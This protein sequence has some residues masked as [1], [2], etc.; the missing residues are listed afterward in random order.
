M[1]Y[2]AIYN[3]VWE[4]LNDNIQEPNCGHVIPDNAK[5][6]PECGQPVELVDT[7]AKIR[8]YLKKNQ[9]DFYGIDEDGKSTGSAKWYEYD[10]N[11]LKLSREFPNYLFT[12]HG[13]G[14]E[15]GDIWNRY[16]FNGKTQ[17]EKAKITFDEF[18]LK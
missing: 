15:A 8:D 9:A 4:S 5:F 10:T 2:Y 7:S 14:E 3:L 11:M 1:G 6:C 18:K 13:E 12:L 17:T 16:Y